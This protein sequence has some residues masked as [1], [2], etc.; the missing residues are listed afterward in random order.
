MVAVTVATAEFQHRLPAGIYKIAL[1]SRVA[2]RE[3]M[4]RQN[5]LFEQKIRLA[6][7]I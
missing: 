3:Y 4:Y 6:F 1:N 7:V 5:E 2:K